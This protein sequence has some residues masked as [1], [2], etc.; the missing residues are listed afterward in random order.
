M[1][2]S[3][4]RGDP[5]RHVSGVLVGGAVLLASIAVARM[6]PGIVLPGLML[7]LAV[8]VIVGEGVMGLPSRPPVTLSRP[9]RT[10]SCGDDLAHEFG[11]AQGVASWSTDRSARRRRASDSSARTE[12]RGAH[13]GPRVSQTV[14]PCE[15]R[16]PWG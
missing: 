5:A 7:F 16:R 8:G 6:A 3:G 15:R 14:T 4:R 9:W 1:S 12:R 2:G 13:L 11:E 10:G